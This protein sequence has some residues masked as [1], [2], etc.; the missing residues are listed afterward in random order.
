MEPE[1]SLQCSQEPK[2]SVQFRGSVQHFVTRWF[3]THSPNPQAGELPLVGCLRILIQYIRS[4]PPYP[5][6][7]SSLRSSSTRKA[8]DIIYPSGKK[9]ERSHERKCYDGSIF[10][11]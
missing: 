7:V 10:K 9:A 6:A 1:G 2:Q 5:E 4:H 11:C 3:F 8:V